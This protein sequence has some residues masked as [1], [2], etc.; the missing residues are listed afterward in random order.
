MAT[1]AEL[2]PQVGYLTDRQIRKCLDAG[3]LLEKG[4]WT[5]SQIRHASYTLRLGSRVELAR[6]ADSIGAV[7]RELRV[8]SLTQ[9]QPDVE[10]KPGDTA[11]L[12]SLESLR[13]PPDVLGFTVARGLLFAEALSPENTYVDPGFTG[14]IYTTVTNVSNRVVTLSYQM[15]VARL[16]FFRLGEEVQDGYRSGS[17][18]GIAQQ[19]T[20]V[21]AVAFGTTEELKAAKEK[22]LLDSVRLIPLGGVHAV[23]ALQ[24]IYRQTRASH[25]PIRNFVCEAYHGD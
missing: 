18:L 13:I 16:F 19:L 6:A 4:T 3:Q 7:S 15:P 23:E 1:V 9:G 20:S 17:A 14:P 24:R 11:L 5:D 2:V 21:R 12:Y 22:E 8:V 25:E 10:L